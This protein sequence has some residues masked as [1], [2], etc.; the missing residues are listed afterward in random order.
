FLLPRTFRK[1]QVRLVHHDLYEIA[2]ASCATT[3]PK[4]KQ[5]IH[6]SIAVAV[7]NPLNQESS[8]PVEF[9]K[10]I[11]GAPQ[12]GSREPAHLSMNEN[13]SRI[14]RLVSPHIR[15]FDL[16]GRTPDVD[17]ISCFRESIGCHSC[18]VT[19]TT[20]LRRVFAGY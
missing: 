12:I 19:D 8:R 10:Q 7:W 18:V 5:N 4:A 16:Q 2:A 3:E 17:F 1:R 20:R 15:C 9:I 11:P 14:R 13:T 6:R